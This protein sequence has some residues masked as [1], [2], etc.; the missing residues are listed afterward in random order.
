M[1]IKEDIINIKLSKKDFKNEDTGHEISEILEY[2]NLKSC[3]LY[4]F[5]IEKSDIEII[6]L[7]SSLAHIKFDFCYFNVEE[8]NLDSKIE[9]IYLN[10][11]ENVK[12][13]HLKNTKAKRIEVIHYEKS[14]I[15]LDLSEFENAE[16]LEELEIHNCKVKGVEGILEKAPK[17]RWLYSRKSKIFDGIEKR[18][19]RNK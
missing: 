15:E 11:C 13:K 2:K 14:N 3:I 10:L 12:M 5:Y 8:I 4:K 9:C 1:G 7:S 6:N 17:F 19:I 16:N 18:Y